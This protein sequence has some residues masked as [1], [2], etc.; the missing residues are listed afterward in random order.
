MVIK[1]KIM[2]SD[3]SSKKDRFAVVCCPNESYRC[4]SG[5][6]SK[7]GTGI[8]LYALQGGNLYIFVKMKCRYRLWGT[9]FITGK[10]KSVS[11]V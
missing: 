11:D 3:L 4:R 1:S 5:I 7:E 9:N 10:K 2:I 8:T 6:K